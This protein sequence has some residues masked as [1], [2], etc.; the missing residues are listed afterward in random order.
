MAKSNQKPLVS[1][2]LPV[3]NGEK[4]LAQAIESILN[5]TLPDFELI[6]IND[7]STD[8]SLSILQKYAKK[9]KRIVILDNPKN[10]GMSASIN[11]A[12][13]LTQGQYIARMDA[14]DI[15]LPFRF[16]LQVAMLKANNNLVAVG[17]Q[18][19][20][21]DAKGQFVAFKYFPTDPNSCYQTLANFMPIQPPAL[22]ARASVLRQL[23]YDTKICPQDDI[24][25]YFKL[26]KYGQISNVDQ[27]AF[28]YRQID[29]SLTHARA[30][31]VYFMAL[32]NRVDGYLNHGYRPSLIRIALAVLESL[33]VLL[34]PTS[35]ITGIFNF[36]RYQ[37]TAI[38]SFN[39]QPA[40]LINRA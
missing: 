24:N 10:M 40:K 23:R 35:W 14:D 17:C 26:L 38:L 27:V 36:L 2:L 8:K 37:K 30:K 39:L 34:I 31:N 19:E 32:R 12:L 3:Y 33:F 13:P 6:C 20:I 4:F 9:D 29:S 18:E 28:R 5:Q 1:V 25:I 22:M 15:S 21:I 16:A 11:H 7:G